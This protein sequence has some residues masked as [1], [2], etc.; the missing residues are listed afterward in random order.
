MKTKLLALLLFAGSSLFAGTHVF[1]GF[2]VGAP[3]H[4]YYAPPLRSVYYAPPPLYARP[5][6]TWIAGYWYP[7]GP[8]Y[9]WRAGYWARPPYPG[10]RWYA[11]RYYNHRYYSGYWRRH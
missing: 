1:F 2:G 4:G 11:P 9:R 3:A 10:A 7:V 5:G 6:Y 8:R